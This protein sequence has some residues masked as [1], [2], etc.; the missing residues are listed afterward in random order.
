[1]WS[2][3]VGTSKFRAAGR[4]RTSVRQICSSRPLS[5]WINSPSLRKLSLPLGGMVAFMAAFLNQIRARRWPKAV[6]W[7]ENVQGHRAKCEID[8]CATRT[9]GRKADEDLEKRDFG[10]CDCPEEQVSGLPTRTSE[11][12]HCLPKAEFGALTAAFFAA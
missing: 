12:F 8:Y 7:N 9:Y 3:S 11:T 1:M 4:R 2:L 10:N 6:L 5:R